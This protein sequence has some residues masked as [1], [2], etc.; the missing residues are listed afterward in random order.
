MEITERKAVTVEYTLTNEA[1]K[2]LDSS[3]SREPLT[4]VQGLGNMI[5]GFEAALEGKKAGDKLSFE[6]APQDA[7]GEKDKSLLISVPKERFQNTPDLTAG[8]RFEVQTP[9]GTMVMAVDRIEEDSVILD[10]NHPLAG[11]RLHF[12]VEVVGVREATS[13]ELA[14]AENHGHGCGCSCDESSCGDSGCGG[15]CH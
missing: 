6:V 1:G 9:N 15:G 4:Y 8:M 10:G 11:S 7:Y 2:V 14:E 12:D 13:E 3:R 5:S